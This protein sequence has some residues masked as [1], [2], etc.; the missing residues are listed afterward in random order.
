MTTSE[1][2]IKNKPEL[3]GSPGSR[4]TGTAR[5]NISFA[6]KAMAYP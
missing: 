1:K 4:V 5:P 3:L 2:V 6:M